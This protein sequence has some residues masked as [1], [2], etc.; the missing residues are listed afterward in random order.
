MAA[1]VG[2]NP[3]KTHRSQIVRIMSVCAVILAAGLVAYSRL[4]A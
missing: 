4:S 3:V 1:F 2:F